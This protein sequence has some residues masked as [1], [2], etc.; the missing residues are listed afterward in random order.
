[1][2]NISTVRDLIDLWPKRSELAADLTCELRR[3]VS[4]DSVH[5][6]AANGGIPAKYQRAVVI[7]ASRR[8][9]RVDAD[10]MLRLHHPKNVAGE[11]AA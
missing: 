10:L 2:E 7:A 4:V 8:G 5:K 3:P 11:D 1:M 6:W 9:F